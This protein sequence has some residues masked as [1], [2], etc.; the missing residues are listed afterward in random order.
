M[1]T[2]PQA[3]T[4]DAEKQRSGPR[5]SALAPLACAWKNGWGF[6]PGGN[7]QLQGRETRAEKGSASL[8]SAAAQ[9]EKP[10]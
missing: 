4:R 1:R 6:H 2:T 9:E 5:D 8:A 7:E 10:R 3:V